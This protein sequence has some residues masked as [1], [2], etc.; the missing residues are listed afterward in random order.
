MLNITN[1]LD[2]KSP[3]YGETNDALKD[4]GD[5]K[6]TVEQ[7]YTLVNKLTFKTSEVLYKQYIYTIHK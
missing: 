5:E 2:Q 1:I 7:F 6:A 3:H 4:K